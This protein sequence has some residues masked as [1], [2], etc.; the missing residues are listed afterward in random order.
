VA[1]F[2]AGA[3]SDQQKARERNRQLEMKAQLAWAKEDAK[4][5]AANAREK[6]RQRQREAREQAIADG[7]AEAEAVT[8]TLQGHLT[9][10]RTLL[11]GVLDEEPYLTWD[12]FKEPLLIAEFKP[13]KRLA[14]EASPPQIADYTPEPPTGLGALAPGRRRAYTRAVEQGEAAYDQ[15]VAAH[16]RDE[17]SR[18]EELA[19]ERSAHERSAS[20]ERDRVRR[21]HAAVDQMAHDF[22]E[23]KRKAVADYFSGVLT[24]RRYPSDFPTGVKVA[25]LP[26]D[27]EL[28]IDIDLPLMTA[29]PELESADY[30]TTKKELKYKRLTV[31]ARN[32]LYQQVVAQMALRTLRCVFAADRAGLILEA[33]CNGYVDTIDTATGQDAHWC[34]VSVQVPRTEFE[35]LDLARVDAM[36]CLAYLHAKVS[37]SPEKYQPVQPII[38]YPWDDL[39]YADELDAAAGLD[40]VQNL[41]DLDGYEFEQLLVKLCQEIP[42]F[43]E[44]RRTRSRAD[45][46]IDLVAVNKTPFVGGRVA[47]QA[48]RYAPHNKVD[49]AAVREIVGSISQR[50]FTKGIIITTSGFTSAAREEAERLGVELYEGERLLWLLRHH[51]HRE[52]NII[53][54]SRRKPAFRKPPAPGTA[55]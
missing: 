42:E 20:R 24:V 43:D 1:G 44:V 25:Y 12:R 8:R 45:G 23:G 6:A 2:I 52:F 41:L 46:G 16:D 47:I 50:E 17:R 36:D 28:R 21:Q 18:M 38:E 29:I 7:H 40:T 31:A 55:P 5:A 49:I 10:L 37:K 34:L 26:S 14:T 4:V 33:T 48:K 11:T 32:K 27:R 30:L 15:A 9:E 53:D 39:H 54:Q 22:A 13:P 19:Q 51:L 35:R 3:V